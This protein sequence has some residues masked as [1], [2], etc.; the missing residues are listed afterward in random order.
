M[1]LF[2]KIRS[3]LRDD[4]LLRRVVRNSSY[5]F[6]S[7]TISAVL[8]AVQ[9][10]LVLRL[11]DPAQY[12]LAT[13]II[14]LFATSVNQL[15]SFRMSEVVVKYAGEALAHEDRQRTAALV[16]GIG[17]TESITSIVAYL[18]LVLLSPWAASVFAKDVSTAP[19]FMFYGLFLLAN[20]VY[21]TSVGTLQT[22]HQFGSVAR[23]NFYQSIATFLSIIAIS[24]LGLGIFGVLIAYLVGKTIAGF[25]VTNAAFRELRGNLGDGWWR[26]PLG[27]VTDWR[28]IGRFM[29]STNLNGTVNLLAR[30][31]IPLYIGY[32]LSP[33]EVGY[34]KFALN[35]INLV[36]LPIEPFIWPTY[37]EITRTIAQRQWDA[38]RKLLR[39]VTTIAGAWTFLTGGGLIA[40]G[41]WIIP[42]IFGA[43]YSPAYPALVI[44]LLGYGCANILNWNRPLLLALGRPRYPVFVALTVG[45]V[46]LALFFLLVPRTNYLVASAIFSGYLVISVLWMV[47]R[48]LGIIKAEEASA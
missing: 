23:A 38:T 40:L 33:T 44:L 21:E 48:G 45:A 41:W 42:L 39:Q 30:D 16:K 19:L 20:I 47:W 28:S 9:M 17:I 18:V 8:S 3:S 5:L 32:L 22:V 10:I 36:K 24:L 35:L 11:L 31:N 15:L 1:F 26:A 4:P 46:E 25:M 37:S 27:L 7:S 14:M 34:F 13:G 6:S 12:G 43:K 2:E 29:L